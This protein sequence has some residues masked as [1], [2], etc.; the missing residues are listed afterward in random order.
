MADFLFCSLQVV[1]WGSV[2]VAQPGHE[3]QGPV[4]EEHPVCSSTPGPPG[5]GVLQ[6]HLLAGTGLLE[7]LAVQRLC[8]WPR[9]G[10][11]WVNPGS[12]LEILSSA[13]RYLRVPAR[14]EGSSQ[15]PSSWMRALLQRWWGSQRQSGD[16]FTWGQ[17]AEGNRGHWPGMEDMPQTFRCTRAH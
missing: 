10:Q 12:L 5:L 4:G 2:E 8:G 17:R 14:P 1:T 3:K 9:K 13:G 15:V 16:V 6:G 11:H 7:I